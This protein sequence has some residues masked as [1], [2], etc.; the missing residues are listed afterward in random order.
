MA[1]RTKKNSKASKRLQF[2][3]QLRKKGKRVVHIH[4]HSIFSI[5]DAM[6]KPKEVAK[7]AK[8][9]GI[10]TIILTDHGTISGIIQFKKACEAEGIKFI[11]ACEMY[12]CE[13]RT[14]MAQA[15]YR[16]WN[17]AR[18][19]TMI[20]VN[21]QGWDDL[22]HLISDANIYTIHDPKAIPR[23]DFNYIE[24][25][26]LG[27]NIIAT[28]GCLAGKVPK[29]IENGE[30]EEAKKEAVR[31]SKIFYEYYLE[32]QDNGS[33]EQEILNHELI[34]MSKETGI[35][36]VY[37]KDVHYVMPEDKPAHHTLVSIGRKQS[38]Y[39][40]APY[41]GTNTYHFAGADEVYKWADDNNV[42]H[43]AIENTCWIAEICNVDI[44]LGK[45]LMP[46][47]PFCEDGH[48]PETYLRKLL[49]D[50]LITYSEKL[51]RVN[52]VIDMNA[53]IHRIETEYSIIKMKGF[54]SYFL[55]LWDILLW[56]TNRKKWASYPANR[57]WLNEQVIDDEW[58]VTHPN[59]KYLHYPEY[60]V[61]PG[62]GSAAGAMVA[63]LLDI[64]R[65][66]PIQYGLLFERFLNPYRN[67]PPDIDIDFPG[68]FHD[69]LLDFVAQRYGRDRTAQI[70]TF[71]KFKLLGSLD[72]IC[73]A[74]ELRDPDTKKVLKYGYKVSDEIK[75]IVKMIA[76][77]GGKMPDQDDATYEIMMDMSV[78]P[79]DY[80]RYGEVNLKKGIEA[81]KQFRKAMDTY[82][83]LHESLKRIEGAID[84]SGIHAGGV[85]ISS[86]P[87]SQ[88]CPTMLPTGKSKAVLPITMWDYPDCEE[89]GLLKMDLLRTAT[90][91]IISEAVELI[92]QSNGDRIDMYEIGREDPDAFK[93]MA[94]G[95]THG[96][97]QV[98][99]GG[100]TS[101]TR[102]VAPTKQDEVID[103]LALYRPGPLDAQLD[104]GNT[105]AQQY[106]I[107]GDTRKLKTYM[108]DINQ[109]MRDALK[110]SRGQMVYQEQ[111]MELVQKIAGYNLAHADTFRRVIGKKKISEMPKL[112]DE[113]MYGHN[114]VIEKFSKLLANYDKMKKVTDEKGNEGVLSYDEFQKK[115]V[116]F[117]KSDIENTIKSNNKAKA[118]FEIKGAIAM[119]F[120]KKF[121]DSLFRQMAAFAGYAFNKS[122]SACY[123]DETYQ[124]A[125]LKAKHPVEF[126]TALLTVRG[127]DK[128]KTLENLKEAKRMGIK[129]LAPNINMSDLGFTPEGD[130]IRFGL[131][132]ILGVGDKAVAY[133]INERNQNGRYND[134]DHFVAR[135]I[136]AFQKTP[137]QK[138]NPV[139]RTVM[140]TLIK[141]GAFDEFQ[142][143]RHKL[144]NYYNVTLRKDKVY[145]GSEE[146]LEKDKKA[147][148]NH[149]VW[150]DEAMFTE[151]RMLEMERELIGIYV[152]GSP[153]EDLP[154]TPLT[155]MKLS[156]RRDKTE[157]EI[158]GRISK[159]KVIKTKKGDAMAFVSIETQLEPLEFTVF[160][161]AYEA[162][163]QHLYQDNIVVVRGYKEESF[164]K[165]EM[166]EQFI[167]TKILTREAKKL[168]KLMGIKGEAPTPRPEPPQADDDL[169]IVA[170][171]KPKNDPVAELFDEEPKKAKRRT[172]RKPMETVSDYL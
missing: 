127:G 125:W 76:S 83:E 126:M 37:A 30:Y 85:I 82:P 31:R 19:I 114:Y 49:Y 92:E 67:S 12:E 168:K 108:R 65:L 38:I 88:D 11:P 50:N 44:E 53:Y 137:E 109:E 17:K 147:K 73:K 122:H 154:F 24:A 165:G 63:F 115:E 113:F 162:N 94:K 104:N 71:T 9:L 14:K 46:A 42:P 87:L 29:L 60:V 32:I 1:I 159:I 18:H 84:T 90:L 10:D 96:L 142:P 156:T 110:T 74:L 119:G 89:L 100:I 47:Y 123:A 130:G 7:R 160:P 105:I 40:C 58:Q 5:A 22:Q 167:G 95:E 145:Y 112:Y 54:P 149:S 68:T 132:S 2:L 61:G 78:N 129:I 8:Q 131:F 16:G 157:Y 48:T 170:Q 25:N 43:E 39:E 69:E 20:P 101:Y 111:I 13:D 41:S 57:K 81:S 86:R 117:T 146:E 138:S 75:A 118:I 153:Y 144:L 150:Y 59:Q 139:N 21:N 33:R 124:T 166:K 64:T 79:Q 3:T 121:A 171:S 103:I 97:F 148:S 55:I 163:N 27:K 120:P 66:D 70:L 136:D 23:T 72:K 152:S 62:R 151:K 51:Q 6:A 107:N 56:A 45:D 128:D 36:L 140:R 34:R 134:F 4:M 35:P 141:A 158:G 102:Q 143:N 116:M 52:K 155:D 28:S 133:I 106:V 93:L 99:G 15:D 98:A 77:D 164:Y 161:D 26:G 91:R 135:I 80:E 172:R 169:A